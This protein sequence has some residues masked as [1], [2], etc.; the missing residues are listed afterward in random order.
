[1]IVV[2]RNQA[3]APVGFLNQAVRL[4]KKTKVATKSLTAS[5][6]LCSLSNCTMQRRGLKSTAIQIKHPSTRC[7]DVFEQMT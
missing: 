1:M 5:F 3:V 2:K 6:E 7:K 4:Y